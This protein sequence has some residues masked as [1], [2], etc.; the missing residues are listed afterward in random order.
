VNEESQG[1]GSHSARQDFD[2]AKSDALALLTDPL[3]DLTRRRQTLLLIAGTITLLIS[4]AVVEPGPNNT[5]FGIGLKLT[6]PAVVG[7]LCA[8]VTVYFLILYGLGTYADLVVRRV[9]LWTLEMAFDQIT[10]KAALEITARGHVFE[11]HVKAR[12]DAT[13][14]WLSLSEERDKMIHPLNV[15]RDA[16]EASILGNSAPD[17]DAVLEQMHTLTGQI[18]KIRTDYGDKLARIERPNDLVS[19]PIPNVRD[20]VM[21]QDEIKYARSREHRITQVRIAVEV[22]APLALGFIAVGRT[23]FLDWKAGFPLFR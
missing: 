4:F 1:T 22:L 13:N 6:Q 20:A 16:L 7:D 19:H 11:S 12:F 5:V 17:T 2:A 3:T 18:S 21:T 10:D 14:R 15:R 23:L 8:A 9:R